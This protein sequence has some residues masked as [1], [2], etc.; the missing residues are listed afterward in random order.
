MKETPRNA[1]RR[2]N[3][4]LFAIGLRR[5]SRCSWIGRLDQFPKREG[6][7]S[8]RKGTCK[9]CYAARHLKNRYGLTPDKWE[10]IFRSQKCLCAICGTNTPGAKGWQTDHDHRTGTVRGIL[11]RPCNQG[12]GHFRDNRITLRAAVEHLEKSL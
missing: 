1:S 2:Y 8:G 6:T 3:R 5:C 11:C 10:S 12:L 4:D 9:G 7:P